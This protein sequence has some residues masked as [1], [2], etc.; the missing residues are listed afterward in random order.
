M[1]YLYKEEKMEY[2]SYLYNEASGEIENI[3]TFEETND[4]YFYI[5]KKNYND[6]YNMVVKA[7]NNVK[8]NLYSYDYSKQKIELSDRAT[9]LYLDIIEK[10]NIE[11]KAEQL[12][13]YLRDRAFNMF[14]KDTGVE[15]YQDGR[16]GRHIVVEDNFYNA[17]NYDKLCSKQEK[18]E[19]WLI[20]KYNKEIKKL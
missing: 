1:S 18:Y 3:P 17:Y 20:N 6:I 12:Y 9:L 4:Y 15:I 8:D 16:S 2:A 7:I 19:N 13:C 14:E 5:T 11:Y 10:E